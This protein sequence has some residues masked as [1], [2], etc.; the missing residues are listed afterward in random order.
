MGRRPPREGQGSGREGRRNLISSSGGLFV[1]HSVGMVGLEFNGEGALNGVALLTL[2]GT[3]DFHR[4]EERLL[5]SLH[6]YFE[7]NHVPSLLVLGSSYLILRV[8]NGNRT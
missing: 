1:R 3:A 4:N 6:S 2:G 7:I 8:Q 5:D